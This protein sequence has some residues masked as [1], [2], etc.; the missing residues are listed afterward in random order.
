[1]GLDLN[2]HIPGDEEFKEDIKTLENMK[3]FVLE[4]FK[5]EMS[6]CKV[7]NIND[8]CDGVIDFY[9]M[10]CGLHELVSAY[11]DCKSGI[12]YC[13]C[14][15]PWSVRQ[16]IF[17]ILTVHSSRDARLAGMRKYIPAMEGDELLDGMYKFVL[18]C[19][20]SQGYTKHEVSIDCS[21]LTDDG[22]FLLRL[23]EM[24]YK[25]LDLSEVVI[26]KNRLNKESDRRK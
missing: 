2:K 3:L 14:G 24:Y 21:T 23:L 26:E 10:E 5:D 25:Y 7:K 9:D 17:T 12:P 8:Y 19:L 13:G 22:R 6:S 4:K 20:E 11:E 1:M 16:F 15:N 18:H